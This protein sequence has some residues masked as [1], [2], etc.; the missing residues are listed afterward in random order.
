MCGFGIND[1]LYIFPVPPS[2]GSGAFPTYLSEAVAPE[3]AA[4]MSSENVSAVV[5]SVALEALNVGFPVFFSSLNEQ[6][7]RIY[8]EIF[9]RVENINDLFS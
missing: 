3:V 4:Q 5:Q 8:M 6:V 1:V 2:L 9:C 7:R